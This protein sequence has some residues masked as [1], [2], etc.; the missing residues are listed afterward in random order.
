MGTTKPSHACCGWQEDEIFRR[1]AEAALQ[2]LKAE[3]VAPPRPAA[4]VEKVVEAP[5]PVAPTKKGK[6]Q[7]AAKMKEGQVRSGEM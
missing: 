7:S 3:P 4:V 1:K 2:A 6:A 5:P